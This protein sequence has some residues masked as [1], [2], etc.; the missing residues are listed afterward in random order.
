M[1]KALNDNPVV[2]I[3]ALGILAVV[4]GFL[5]F[6][7]VMKSDSGTEPAASTTATPTATTTAPTDTATAAPTGTETA[8]VSPAA[9]AAPVD[10]ASAPATGEFAAGPGLPKPVVNA[11]EDG[12]TVALFVYRRGG[13]DDAALASSIQRLRGVSGVA[14]FETR[15]KNVAH[16]S[17]IVGGV[18]IDRAPALVVVTPKG[19]SSGGLPS[20]SISYGFRDFE[21]VAQTVHDAGYHGKDLPYYPR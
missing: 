3:V 8:P 9:P 1:R 13:L 5:L 17:R 14:V 7:R 10:G 19:V 4:V 18:D 12:D 16:Y 6:T 2:Q 20:A 11:Y 21:S 15:A